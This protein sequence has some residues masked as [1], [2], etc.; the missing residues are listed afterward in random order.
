MEYIVKLGKGG[1]MDFHERLKALRQEKKV[2]QTVI[3]D[4]LNVG[5]RQVSYYESGQDVP[6]L[7]L[8]IILADYFNV[9]LDYLA[10]RTDNPKINE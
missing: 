6:P 2:N 7:P 3:A 10:G 8:L 1:L 9:S 5:Q 4:I